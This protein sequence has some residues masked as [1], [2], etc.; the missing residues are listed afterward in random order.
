MRENRT[1]GSEGGEGL[2]LPDP[3]R[4][5]LARG[6]RAMSDPTHERKRGTRFRL[7]VDAALASG[8]AVRASEAQAHYVRSVMRAR[9]G[10]AVALFNGRDG[11]WLATIDTVERSGCTL[12]VARQSRPQ[13]AEPD[14]WLAFAPIRGA[15]VDFIAQKATELG[16]ARL[17][18]V[19]T[20]H[21]QVRAV[22]AARL[23]ANAVE[24]AEQCGRLTVPA[25]DA[26]VPLAQLL[27]AWPSERRLLVADESGAG[28]PIAQAVAAVGASAGTRPWG[29][30]VGPEGGFA[31]D[32]LA[33]L[34]A[35][36][37]ATR[38][39]LGP[40]VLRADTAA[41]AALAVVQAVAGDWSTN[42]LTERPPA[43]L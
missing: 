25:V 14:P 2:A 15:R 43:A 41:I 19:V 18:P 36:P 27:D 20:R 11:E 22:N 6:A 3:Y 4:V 29:I 31:A 7:F 26:L 39:G 5:V 42:A 24:A 35:L 17:L 32:E 21:T 40:R 30:L 16:V 9:V 1:C 28:V 12:R 13:A 23:R 37:F 33:A 10:E 38:A 8:A 34:G